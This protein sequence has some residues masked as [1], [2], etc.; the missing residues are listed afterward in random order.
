[1]SEFDESLLLTDDERAKTV[2]ATGALDEWLTSATNETSCD[3]LET[4]EPLAAAT[5]EPDELLV[6]FD[7]AV[8]LESTIPARSSTLN[9]APGADEPPPSPAINAEDPEPDPG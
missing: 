9:P 2:L 5:V 3:E 1:M 4:D 7:G 8:E 6:G